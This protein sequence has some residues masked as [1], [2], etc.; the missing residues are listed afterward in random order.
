LS[1]WLTGSARTPEAR[2]GPLH[3]E[4]VV[5]GDGTSRVA[6]GD[7]ESA[8]CPPDVKS[9]QHSV[10]AA[11]VLSPY[12]PCK[13]AVTLIYCCAGFQCF[14]T[15]VI[16]TKKIFFP[17]LRGPLGGPDFYFCSSQPDAHLHCDTTD[18]GLIYRVVCWFTPQLLL[19]FIFLLGRWPGWVNLGGW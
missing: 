8:S 19:A 1:D 16:D 4:A 7:C 9:V 18:M 3:S 10:A 6:S 17:R 14:V 15:S 2:D 13:W 11:A 12:K 5:G